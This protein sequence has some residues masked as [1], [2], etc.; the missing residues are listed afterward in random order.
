MPDVLAEDIKT[1][2]KSI[3]LGLQHD[4]ISSPIENIQKQLIDPHKKDDPTYELK[5]NQKLDEE[6]ER[7]GV[8]PQVMLEYAESMFPKFGMCRTFGDPNK[9]DNFLM[10]KFEFKQMGGPETVYRLNPSTNSIWTM[11]DR[12]TPSFT[13]NSID[14]MMLQN[15]YERFDHIN[16]NYSSTH[17]GGGWLGNQ[18]FTGSI[19]VG[20]VRKWSARESKK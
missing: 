9:I 20:D 10:H 17:R 8:L 5:F 11:N 15:F 12:L 18:V 14:R 6:L 4:D 7:K 1:A 19:T 3:E 13:P 16:R 2:V